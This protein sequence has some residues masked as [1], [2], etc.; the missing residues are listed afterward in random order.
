MSIGEPQAGRALCSRH[1]N[2]FSTIYRTS[3]EEFSMWIQR[4][5]K[6]RHRISDCRR[7]KPQALRLIVE[8]L[9]DLA[10]PSFALPVT[11]GAELAVQGL[12]AADFNGDGAIDLAAVNT[13]TNTV[14]MLL[15]SGGGTF[16]A[17]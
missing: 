10:M 15:G 12:A 9:E 17:P 6:S 11:Y 7:P 8:T 3:L 16:Q 4:F 5:F 1:I 2:V 14:S 13:A